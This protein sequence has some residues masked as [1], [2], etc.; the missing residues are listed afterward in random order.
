MLLWGV[1]IGL[2]DALILWTVS[3]DHWPMMPSRAEDLRASMTVLRQGGPLLLGRHGLSGSFYSIGSGET[4]IYVYLPLLSRLLGVADP[5]SLVR[6]CY[7]VLYGLTAISYPAVFYKLTGSLLA[8]LAAPILLLLCVAS[9]GFDDTYWI[10]AWGALTLLPLIY[11]LATHWPRLGWLA[12]VAISFS[13]GWLSSIRESSGLPLVI[14]AVIVLLI[15]RSRARRVPLTLALLVVAYISITTFVFGVIRA[16]SAHRLSATVKQEQPAPH[17]WHTLYIGLGYLPNDYGIRYKDEIAAERVQR[18]APGTPYLSSRYVS[19]I[20]GAYFDVVDEH[21]I[22]VL[23]QYTAKALVTAADAFP[24]LLP[25]LLAIPAM[26][27]LGFDPR[28]RRQWLLLTVPVVILGFSPSLVAI[29][30]QS[31]E[32]GLYAVL[33]VVAILGLGWILAQFET[34]IVQQG[35]RRST[36]VDLWSTWSASRRTDG[37]IRRSARITGLAFALFIALSVGGHFI[38]RSADRWQ[39]IPSGVLAERVWK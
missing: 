35:G 13:A 22:E 17:P 15:H 7:V 38:R 39:G 19:V 5:V 36:L 32:L 29:P 12:L 31:Y 10:L 1:A 34:A 21:P 28:R 14:A 16:H 26:L 30:T 37:G 27:L 11:L 20:R 18:E 33:G 2:V 6:Y 24:Y 3:P 9:M 23:W 4:G 8:G 25:S